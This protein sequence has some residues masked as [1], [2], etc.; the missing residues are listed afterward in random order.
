MNKYYILIV[1]L[2][3]LPLVSAN[4]IVD[5]YA[6]QNPTFV[7]EQKIFYITLTNNNSYPVY[8][9]TLS[10]ISKYVFA[11]VGSLAIG[12]SKTVPYTILNNDVSSGTFVSTISY[13]FETSYNV[14]S[15][16]YSETIFDSG[17]SVCNL[18]L[19][20]NDS[21]SW[22]N[23]RSVSSEVKSL[24]SGWSNILLSP[25]GFQSKLYDVVGSWMFYVDGLP[26]CY[27]NVLPYN[28]VVYAHDSFQDIPVSFVLSTT[29][30]PSSL[31]LNALQTNF[32]S[33]NNQ[34]QVGVL[35]VKNNGNYPLYNVKFNDSNGWMNFSVQD[36]TMD[37][38]TNRLITFNLTPLIYSTNESNMTHSITIFGSS[39]NGG[40]TS[41]IISL[42][43]PF[44]DLGNSSNPNTYVINRLSINL[45]IDYC[46]A[47]PDDVECIDLVN[48]FRTNNTVIKEIS[49]SWSIPEPEVKLMIESAKN[50]QSLVQNNI[51][52]QGVTQDYMLNI[53]G[54]YDSSIIYMSAVYRTVQLWM[55]FSD[56]KIRENLR[57]IR[58]FWITLVV[59]ILINLI[60]R[61]LYLNWVW[62]WKFKTLQWN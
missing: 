36:F 37:A 44:T 61:Y 18:T 29:V 53:S 30:N 6:Q 41:K 40:N 2:L 42:F 43:I 57:D 58:I 51:N 32:S 48:A 19:M 20:Q 25:L 5:N 3:F 38:M 28:N 4:L 45:T 23:N 26:A 47:N 31:V 39:S 21:I 55:D 14:T 11:N 10:P 56:M 8:N 52:A 7:G 22:M 59:L 9:V 33:F 35:E 12:E 1:F 60:L 17:F 62:S 34:T 46:M 27:L 15:K 54:K 24:N 13:F 49:A 50:S 16:A